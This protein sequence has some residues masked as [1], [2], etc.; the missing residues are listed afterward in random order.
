MT[1]RAVFFDPSLRRWWWVK[2]IGTLLGL[3]AVLTV[4]VW[5]V[6]LF[7]APLLPGVKGITIAIKRSMRV[8]AH[9]QARTQYLLKRDR[10]RL[11]ARISKDERDRLARVSKGPIPA[12]ETGK[13]IVAAFYAPWQET[14]LH[15]LTANANRMTH[16]LPVWVHLRSDANGLDF[17][18]W[19][20]LLTPHNADV[21]NIAHTNNLNVVPVFS[22]AQVS[23]NG[24]GEFDPQRVHIFLNDPALQQ[25]VIL[26]LQHWCLSNHFQGINVDFESLDPGD[27]P[28]LIPF[29]QRMRAAFAPRHLLVSV[30]LEAKS[31][32]NAP[33]GTLDWHAVSSICDFVVVMAYDEHSEMSPPGPIASISWY[34]D[35][36]ARAARSI[37]REKLVIGMANYA[38]DWMEG[39]EWAEPLTYQ[40]ALIT[41]HDY[42]QG[43]KPEDIVDFDSETLNPT[44]RYQ[45]D[46]QK[47]HEVWMLDGVTAANQWLIAQN[48]S[49]RGMAIWVLGSSDPSIWTFINRDHLDQRP[50]MNALSRV[51][52]P[53]D[54]EF[55]GDGEIAH[56]DK[57]PTDGL[58]TLE[59]DPQTGLVLDEDYHSF[60]TSYVIGRTGYKPNRIALTIDD[61]P[62]DPYTSDILD[63]LKELHVPATFFLI[64]RN[65][66][67]YPGL[68]R[69]IWAEG[70][71]IG[72]HTFTHPNIGEISPQ[73]A[74][75]EM[76]ATQRVFQS[77]LHRS[78]LLFRPP[79]N[80][81]AEPT[82]AFEVTPI[83]LASD[84]NYITVLEYID[85]QDWNTAERMPNGS[86]RHRKAEDMLQTVLDQLATERG[87]C[88]LI[89][90][91]GGERSETVRLIPLL[92]NELHRRGY[93]FVP[94]SALIDSTRDQV[95]P[96]VSSADTL[97]L[98]NDR[99]VFEAIYLFELFL[100]IAF[101]TAII[102]GTLR[103]LFVTVLALIAKWRER[104]ETFDDVRPAVSVVIAAYNEEKVIARTIRAVMANGY[105]P[106]EIIVV[107]DG[108]ADDTSGEVRATFG[109]AVTLFRQP[110]GGKSAAL[111]LGIAAATGEI[112]IA[113]DADTVFA[114]DTIE[115]LVRHFANPLVGAVAGNV[116]VGNRM[117]PLTHWQS[118]EYVTSQ[119]LDRRAYAM[120]NSVTVVPGAVGAW[121]REAILQAGGYTTDTMA[122]DMDLTWRIRRIGWR[123]ETE[124]KAFGYTE[125]PDSFR[126]LFKQRFRWAFGT[127]QSLW[128]HRRA[129]GRYGW[130]G[131]VML[132]A[133]WLFQVA[134]QVLSPLVDLQ[135]L[136]SLGAVVRAWARGRLVGDWQPLPSALSSLYLIGFMYAFFFV[137]ELIGSLVA[138]KLDGEDPRALVWLF[139]QRFLYRQ[140]MYAVILRSIKTAVSGMRTGWGKLERKGT[141]EMAGEA[142]EL[143]VREAQ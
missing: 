66:E 31:D 80:A 18:D 41:A 119:N 89:H 104:N 73:E 17:H 37:P 70:H 107:D 22:N 91:G 121:R 35:V 67:R 131:R 94:V 1:D 50:D 72:N 93:I 81:D 33:K 78:T 129:M 62:A 116:K 2:R 124:S 118:I 99:L 57:N 108:S 79:Y 100:G 76:N 69:R 53:Y 127:L 64:G 28:L 8:P 5:L 25:K 59:I 15:S 114:R 102:L 130:F 32:R 140:L 113:L 132:P 60:P 82:Q 90:D 47:W 96:P 97:M 85:T 3:L 109:D 87:S 123:I 68:V 65:A 16:L 142:G 6:S 11:L 71:E 75:L 135:I 12:I 26:D 74:R 42:R 13:S 103:V 63:E 86:I 61:G 137:V 92:V 45:D 143:Q 77:L 4:S 51:K 24:S 43:E 21:L 98:A 48:Y 133:L 95:N 88:I 56:V 101:V 39:R 36:V 110:N 122:E 128:K 9:Q 106:L 10:E 30:D 40:A 49:V 46:D 134:F 14:G 38:Y 29:L 52:Y 111:N 19:D 125:A 55:I 136:W 58:R 34:R 54:V 120:I 23:A 126:A 7:T 20:P 105:E 27:Y 112:I 84:L 83:K 139:W 138:Y 141:V 117:N 115:K 44:F